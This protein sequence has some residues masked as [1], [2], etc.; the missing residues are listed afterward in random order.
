[1]SLTKWWPIYGSDAKCVF[2]LW[3]DVNHYLFCDGI[4]SIFSS[5][6][7]RDVVP[8]VLWYLEALLIRALI[9]RYLFSIHYSLFWLPL[10]RTLH[11]FHCSWWYV[12]LR[13]HWYSLWKYHCGLTHSVLCQGIACVTDRGPVDIDISSTMRYSFG[14]FI[15]FVLC[16]LRVTVHSISLHFLRYTLHFLCRFSAFCSAIC[17]FYRSLHLPCCDFTCSFPHAPFSHSAFSCSL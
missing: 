16:C 12:L 7:L 15:A 11:M 2:H 5:V 6:T 9:F 17:S 3:Y 1:M 14:L 4:Y 13:D 10:S 8:S